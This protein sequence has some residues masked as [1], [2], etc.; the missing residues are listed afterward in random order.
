[1]VGP[2]F[3]APA[4]LDQVDWARYD[5]IDFGCSAG[6]SIPY[7]QRRFHARHGLGVDIDPAKVAKARAAG[8]HAVQA[9]GARLA[10]AFGL[11]EGLRVK[12]VSMIHFLEHLPSARVAEEIIA[13]AAK[14]GTDF[15]FIRHPSFEGEAQLAH[16]GLRQY[17]WEWTGHP[18]HLRVSDYCTMFDRLGL[19]QYLIRYHE[20]IGDSA[21]Q[22]ILRSD[23]PKDQ[24]S[25]D[26]TRHRTRPE[27][28]FAEPLWREQEIFVALRAFE[29]DEW[30]RI[31]KAE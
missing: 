31:T 17:W 13:S 30:S 1:L 18:N 12:F 23:E 26:P 22:S 10:E 25:F 21:H 27:V 15:L 2:N 19:H 16:L 8:L 9:D 7:C 14:V 20:P 29:V 6:N 28:R 11:A 4:S 24:H 3:P 5:F